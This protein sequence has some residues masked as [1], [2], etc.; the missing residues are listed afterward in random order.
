MRTALVTQKVCWFEM[1][2][3]GEAIVVPQASWPSES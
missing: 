1:W 3:E 2:F